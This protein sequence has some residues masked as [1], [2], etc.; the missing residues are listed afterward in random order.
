MRLSF[1]AGMVDI[2]FK[3]YPPRPETC[4]SFYPRD[5]EVVEYTHG[6]KTISNCRAALFGKHSVV[7][8]RYVGRDFMLVQVV[9]QP[10]GLYRLTGIPAFEF[11]NTYLD[12]ETIFDKEIRAVNERLSSAADFREMLRIVEVYL[13]QLA[14][15]SRK[16][17]HPIDAVSSLMLNAPEKISLD[18]LAK[19]SF[20]SPKQFERKFVERVGINP[21]YFARIIRFDRAFRLKNAQPHR[22]W[23]GIAIECGYYDYQHLV[24]DYKE[25][26]NFSPNAFYLQEAKAPE[27][28]FGIRET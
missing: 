17:F 10:N 1:P 15:Q 2:P 6:G 8:N 5:T 24:K 9:F 11:T 3:P 21:K 22:D 23:F 4:L 16:E 18:W 27:R 20:L 12:A 13:T 7:T 28:H 26:T 25:F 14:A 19:E